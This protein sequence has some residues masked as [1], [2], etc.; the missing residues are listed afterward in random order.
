MSGPKRKAEGDLLVQL[1]DR[2]RQRYAEPRGNPPR[3]GARVHLWRLPGE[4][5]VWSDG[6][7]AGTWW[8]QP[9]DA[10]AHDVAVDLEARPDRGFPV[11]V[12][13]WKGCVAVKSK[14]IIPGAAGSGR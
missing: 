9:Q 1:N 12:K 11:V 13:V 7:A 14:D 6:P 5:A 2:E 10:A 4:W 3:T 8:L